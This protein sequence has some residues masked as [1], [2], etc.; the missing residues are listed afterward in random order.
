MPIRDLFETDLDHMLPL[1]PSMF[2]A[3]DWRG[4]KADRTG[5]VTI[6]SNRYLAGPKWHSM[7]LMA[8]VRALRVELRSMD[9]EPI[10]TLERRWGRSPDT[11]MDPLSL[12]AI[13]ARKPRSWG[14]S[15]IR[16]DFPE[17]T[18]VLLDRMEPRERGLLVDDIWTGNGVLDRFL[19]DE[20]LFGEFLR[21]PVSEGGV[22]SLV[23][24]PPHIV[25]EV[26][27]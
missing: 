7:R 15:P 1:P 20:S 10:V 2:D 11:A 25:V 17:E 27:A 5:T 24:E 9:G 3:C 26:G 8:G 6:D 22:E 4:V 19:E 23:V 16:S 13:I 12:L 18:R 14:E 21:T